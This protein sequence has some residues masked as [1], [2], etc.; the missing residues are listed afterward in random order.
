MFLVRTHMK[1]IDY[2]LDPIL[3][4]IYTSNRSK[5]YMDIFCGGIILLPL[6]AGMYNIFLGLFII[7]IYAIESFLEYQESKGLRLRKLYDYIHLDKFQV[8][9][10]IALFPNS[11]VKE[12]VVE[13][14]LRHWSVINLEKLYNLVKE[15]MFKDNDNWEEYVTQMNIFPECY[16]VREFCHW[17]DSCPDRKK[18]RFIRKIIS[19]KD[20]YMLSI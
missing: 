2:I 17:I 12:P 13:F 4:K 14:F 8:A 1:F 15:G 7:A 3:E 10:E 16:G 6:F 5:L 18:M 20:S 9:N 11:N 19:Q